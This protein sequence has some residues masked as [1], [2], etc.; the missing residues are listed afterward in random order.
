MAAGDHELLVD[1]NR[2][3]DDALKLSERLAVVETRQRDCPARLA[4]EHGNA[5]ARRMVLLTAGLLLVAAV[6][7][8]VQLCEHRKMWREIRAAQAE[9]AKV[10]TP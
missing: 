7:L 6:G 10:T 5:S 8:F 4:T 1:I 3:L 2:K 9:P